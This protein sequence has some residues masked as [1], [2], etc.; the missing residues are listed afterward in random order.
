MNEESYTFALETT[1]NELQNNCPEISTTFIFKDNQIIAKNESSD[2][3][4]ADSII[5]TFSE[6][7]DSIT[8]LGNLETISI[9]TSKGRI[10]ISKLNDF[11]IASVT[12]KILDDNYTKT[13]LKALISTVTRLLEKFD[14]FSEKSEITEA[15][16][17]ESIEDS[18]QDD[19]LELEPELEEAAEEIEESQVLEEIEEPEPVK[20]QE[21]ASK[22][23]EVLPDPPVTQLMVE[24]L[25]GLLVSSD[26]VRIDSA[27]IAGWTDLYGEKLI[28]EVDLESL[29]GQITRCKFREI[30]SSKHEGKGII[31]MPDKIQ[32]ILETS[33]GELV[34]IK[35]VIE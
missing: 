1:L 11:F 10:H 25:G 35:P 5:N 7:K 12:S 28:E 32:R 9:Q 27:I 21:E 23:H 16:E 26:T 14:F 8:A 22:K 20:K 18:A 19:E 24:N 34:M 4:T 3:K 33:K 15:F 31:R 6:L 30:K 17:P 13:L 2:E 29:N